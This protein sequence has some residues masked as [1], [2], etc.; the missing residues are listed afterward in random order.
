MH[1]ALTAL[2]DKKLSEAA[3]FVI[4]YMPL[5]LT[6]NQIYEGL[7]GEPHVA[8]A[9]R[10]A[11]QYLPPASV[12]RRINLTIDKQELLVSLRLQPTEEYPVFLIPKYDLKVT[13]ESDLGRALTL[14]I[15][16]T[17][18][19]EMLTKTWDKFKG[20]SPDSH[21]LG[22]LFPWLREIMLNFDLF[23]L[24]SVPS[25]KQEREQIEREVRAIHRRNPP[26]SFPRLSIELNRVCQ[27]GKRLFGQ[28][29]MLEAAM[30]NADLTRSRLSID[31]A[32]SLSPPWLSDHLD[33]AVADWFEQ[34]MPITRVDGKPRGVR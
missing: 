20:A 31:R 3:E 14:S 10:E 6:T 5:D 28:Y 29:R 26:K 13:R 7:V 17:R 1:A 19:W 9:F 8:Q 33:E 23:T 22:F 4:R 27:S 15:Q 2:I 12:N 25:R 24:D 30:S 16:V 34:T 18:E 11:I 21:T 32:T